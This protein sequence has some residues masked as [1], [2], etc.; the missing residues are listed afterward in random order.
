MVVATRTSEVFCTRLAQGL[1][2]LLARDKSSAL[3]NENQWIFTS[4]GIHVFTAGWG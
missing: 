4:T 2:T 3:K 1:H